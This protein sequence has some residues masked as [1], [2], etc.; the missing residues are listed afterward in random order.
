MTLGWSAVERVPKTAPKFAVFC[1]LFTDTSEN[2][3]KIL[4]LE[5]ERSELEDAKAKLEKELK[6]R[7]KELEQEKETRVTMQDK[8]WKDIGGLQEKLYDIKV[9]YHMDKQPLQF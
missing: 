1:R 4:T 7:T 2:A 6:E 5:R 8:L 9:Q 3:K